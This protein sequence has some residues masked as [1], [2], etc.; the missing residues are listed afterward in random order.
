MIFKFE[1]FSL[2]YTILYLFTM[3]K[4]AKKMNIANNLSYFYS[5]IN[6]RFSE[7]SIRILIYIK[8]STE[9]K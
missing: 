5:A 3:N 8:N 2:F 6:N 4:A 1:V 9:R 7:F